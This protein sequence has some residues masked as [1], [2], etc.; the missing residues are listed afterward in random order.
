MTEVDL[1]DREE[2]SATSDDDAPVTNDRKRHSRVIL[3]AGGLLMF[4]GVAYATVRQNQSNPS[5]TNSQ[6]MAQLFDFGL[7]ARYGGMYNPAGDACCASG[8]GGNCGSA[9]CGFGGSAACCSQ[10]FTATCGHKGAKA[11]CKLSQTKDQVFKAETQLCGAYGGIDHFIRHKCC[12]KSCGALC[13]A[14]N[15]WQAA[16]G[17]AGCCGT[18]VNNY[19][20]ETN[21]A[22]CMLGAKPGPDKCN[23][24]GGKLHKNMNKCCAA[25]CGA[26]C[27]HKECWRA[28]GGAK[29]CCQSTAGLPTC[30][31]TANAMAPCAVELA[32]NVFS[33]V[34]VLTVSDTETFVNHAKTRE[35]CKG[36]VA[37]MLSLPRDAVTITGISSGAG[38]RLTADQMT[39]PLVGYMVR[40]AVDNTDVTV[41]NVAALAS[42]IAPV[43]NKELEKQGVLVS[44][45]SAVMPIPSVVVD[46]PKTT[47]QKP[48]KAP[49]PAPTPKPTKA[50]TKA[51]TE[52]PK[53]EV[54]KKEEPKKE[55]AKKE[56]PKKQEPKKE[57]PKKEEP[58]KEEAKKDEATEKATE[59]PTKAP[60]KE[61]KKEE[62]KKDETTE[63]A[64]E[65]P[66]EAPKKKSEKKP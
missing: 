38:R 8:C 53:K 64:T 3:S 33:G 4:A 25:E 10:S 31:I 24:Y 11:P 41:A 23:K 47:T 57:E 36:A 63:K 59:K 32:M 12:D 9:T 18:Q 54:P 62:A 58:K 7:C 66:T 65:K 34:I 60:K 1:D 51:P 48:T 5:S 30:S 21:T 43:L 28:P 6:S 16:A 55:E 37:S 13:G 40:V 29:A 56:E 39:K 44:V 15:C 61:S 17:S 27:G 20:L 26:L 49:T 52:A 19:C 46:R 2:W 35:A 45:T 22:P 14:K 42:S 50:P